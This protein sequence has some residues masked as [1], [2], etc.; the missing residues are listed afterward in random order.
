MRPLFAGIASGSV[1]AITS[2]ISLLEVL[3]HPY[4]KGEVV[5]AKKYRQF[6]LFSNGLTTFEVTHDIAERA[7]QL[8]AMYGMRTPDAIQIAV[9]LQYGADV[10]LTNDNGL[11]RV[12]E[13]R[14]V[15]LDDQLK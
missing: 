2:T 9:G 11:K 4:R 6:L 10:L 15:T 8:R 12:S 13:I 5:L 7:A 1:E 14:V 3:V